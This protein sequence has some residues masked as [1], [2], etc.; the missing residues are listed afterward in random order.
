MGGDFGGRCERGML[1]CVLL[2]D[3]CLYRG[4]DV[5]H[6]V[7]RRGTTSG[8]QQLPTRSVGYY[9]IHGTAKSF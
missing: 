8:M 3:R 4:C 9:G 2:F 6:A 1:A 5:R 7:G